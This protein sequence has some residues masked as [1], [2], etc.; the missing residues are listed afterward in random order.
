MERTIPAP[1]TEAAPKTEDQ[2]KPETAARQIKPDELRALVQACTNE[3]AAAI[4]ADIVDVHKGNVNPI[5]IAAQQ[6]VEMIRLNCLIDTLI[7]AA[8]I[9]DAKLATRLIHGLRA[10]AQEIARPKIARAVQVGINGGKK[11]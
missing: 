11:R 1:V 7:E 8:V 10:A 4:A 5:P 9:S 6:R 2:P 3:L